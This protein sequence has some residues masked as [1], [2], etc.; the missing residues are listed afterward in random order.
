MKKNKNKIIIAKNIINTMNELFE[1]NDNYHN[2]I[3]NEIYSYNNLDELSN[4]DLIKKNIILTDPII[5]NDKNNKKLDNRYKICDLCDFKTLSTSAIIKHYET[6]KH[7]NKLNPIS[8]KCTK[9]NYEASNKWNLNLHMSSQHL[10]LDDKKKSKF[11]CDICDT[12]F[13]SDK[14]LI[15]HNEGKKHK[16]QLKYNEII[17]NDNI[18]TKIQN[19]KTDTNTLYNQLN[20]NNNEL[21]NNLIINQ[22]N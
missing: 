16:N 15:K 10:E 3:I 22:N 20:N 5:D 13:F 17:N 8:T 7:K 12:I 6:N 11:Y 1:D 2:N 21:S 14:Y 18:D 9:C 19:I 4:T